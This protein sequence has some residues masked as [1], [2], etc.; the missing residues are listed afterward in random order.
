MARFNHGY[1]DQ[2]GPRSSLDAAVAA[3]AARQHGVICHAQLVE[4]GLGT[5]AIH[6]RVLNH[7]LQRLHRGVYA[8][9]HRGL[10][11]RGH[12][13]AAVFACGPEAV[14]S[15]RSAARLWGLLRS[16][17]GGIEVTAPR[18]REARAGLTVHTTR[19]LTA[20]DRGVVE[21]IPV[22]SVA[23]TI[24]DL[25]ELLGDAW[26]GRA[27]HEAEVR[28]LFDLR[29]V[30]EALG[31]VPAAGARTGSGACSPATAP[32]TTTWQARRSAAFSPCAALAAC[33]RRDRPSSPVARSTSTGR[34]PGWPWR[35]TA[36]RT[37]TPAGRFTRIEVETALWPT[38]GSQVLRV[39][40]T[41]LQRPAAVAREIADV[42]AATCAPT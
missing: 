13:L 23:R 26:L 12:E 27:I 38:L 1:R 6:R 5:A 16:G 35:W 34:G 24:V 40:W 2:D 33:R 39:T 14:L 22:T 28:R 21:A 15:H 4:L 32:R 8:V 25:A 20:A 3:L 9:G 31:R 42:Y 29:A 30:E 10:T 36:P 7:R 41:D 17:T 19:C 37:T 18:T 11:L